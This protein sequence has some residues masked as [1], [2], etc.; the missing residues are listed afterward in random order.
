MWAALRGENHRPLDLLV[1]DKEEARARLAQLRGARKRDTQRML[2]GM[3]E[4]L[5]VKCRA[6]RR[7]ERVK[8]SIRANKREKAMYL[9]LE[10]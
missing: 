6:L 3:L 7:Q 10:F 4:S 1:T 5:R 8:D 2:I 9:D